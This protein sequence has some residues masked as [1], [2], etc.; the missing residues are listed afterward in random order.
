MHLNSKVKRKCKRVIAMITAVVLVCA[1]STFG[2]VAFA[3]EKD[4][5]EKTMVDSGLAAQ[6][7]GVAKVVKAT[8]DKT[9]ADKS[10][11]AMEQA[12]E[13][14]LSED[15]CDIRKMVCYVYGN[16]DYR[17]TSDGVTIDSYTG[18]EENIVIP[19]VINGYAVT[20]IGNNAFSDCNSIKRITI[21]NSVTTIGV[22][23]FAE[24]SNL[25][26]VIIPKS[27]TTIGSDAFSGCTNLVSIT[28]PD[29]VTRLYN[30]FTGCTKLENVMLP[31]TLTCMGGNFQHCTSL[32][33]ITIPNSVTKMDG[34]DFYYC[35]NLESI[36]I[37]G[38]VES[39]GNATFN[40]CSNLK[41]VTISKGVSSI[42]NCAFGGC[43]SLSS[44]TIPGSVVS[45][46]YNAFIGCVEME[47]VIILDGVKEIMEQAFCNCHKLN[48]VELP[49]SVTKLGDEVFYGCSELAY[50]KL[51]NNLTYISY[52]LFEECT[53]LSSIIIPNNITRIGHSFVNCTNLSKILIPE[54]VESI[55]S[56][57]FVGCDDLII[58]CTKDSSAHYFAEQNSI[59]YSFDDFSETSIL[60]R[61]YEK[62][63][64]EKI[65]K[66]FNILG[67]I[68]VNDAKDANFIYEEL[69]R[70]E[71]VVG[72][73]SIVKIN[74]CKIENQINN[75]YATFVLNASALKDGKTNVTG[76]IDGQSVQCE[77]DVDFFAI[78][79][80]SNSFVH[81]SEDFGINTYGIYDGKSIGKVYPTSLE[82]YS[83]LCSNL[84]WS[85]EISLLDTMNAEEWDGS[86]EG[87]S[88]SMALANM[89]KLDVSN[90]GDSS[91]DYYSKLSK[92]A[93]NLELRDLINY[94]QLMQYAN[95]LS[96]TKI[97]FN[98]F[99]TKLNNLMLGWETGTWSKTEFWKS[100]FS[101][102]KTAV[103]NKVP[104][105][106][107]FGYNEGEGHTVLA[108]GYED[109]REDGYVVIKLY[110]CNASSPASVE[111]GY[112]FATGD[113][114]YLFVSED[115]SSFALSTTAESITPY[116]KYVTEDNWTYFKYYDMDSMNKIDVGVENNV[117]KSS[118]N[119]SS[120]DIFNKKMAIFQVGVSDKLYLEN[121]DGS[122]LSFDGTEYS[123][124]MEVYDIQIV[125]GNNK[126]FKFFIP[127]DDEF[128]LKKLQDD[129]KYSIL[130]G[131]KYYTV[132]TTG[133]D[134]VSVSQ[135]DGVQI[136]GENYSFALG[137]SSES[138]GELTYVSGNCTQ[139][140]KA[141][142]LDEGIKITTKGEFFAVDI[143]KITENSVEDTSVEGTF[144]EANTNDIA[145]EIEVSH[146]TVTPAS[147][148]TS[149]PEVTVSPQTS[150]TSTTIPI[151]TKKP[152]ANPIV[153]PSTTEKATMQPTA[154]LSASE[155]PAASS[156]VVK[157]ETK[158]TVG[159]NIYTIT[160]V[161]K[162]TVSFY[163]LVKKNTKKATLPETIT[164]NGKKY[165]VT[166]I[167]EKA[168]S[169]NRTITAV[170]IGKNVTDIGAKVFYKCVKLTKMT[171]PSK[172][173][174]IGKQAFEG[175]SKLNL[176]T[177]KTT[178]LTEKNVGKAA[179]KGIAKKA[180]IKVPKSKK[181][182]YQK[183]LKKKGISSKVKVK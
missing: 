106:F 62:K 173:N 44:I 16:F 76:S 150:E 11:I 174:K 143:K 129:S 151:I 1:N 73:N 171:I 182:V 159:N 23:A 117:R 77:I 69:Q 148:Y 14:K 132:E 96:P 81:N 39:I 163:G 120:G 161:S 145:N 167:R 94:Y 54:N 107:G 28:I 140:S 158:I 103:K 20:A 109:N 125:G 53:N 137:I 29:G 131:D 135:N 112:S 91:A 68:S 3:K 162:R 179:F 149:V 146:P 100:C 15:L 90:I 31:N 26:D 102:I 75:Y 72:D 172:V 144:S 65:G 46:G 180:V 110:D 40:M 152:T 115:L 133:A 87:L 82:Y 170:T 48:S 141:S 17:I 89:G 13:N 101:D 49:D 98:K 93:N 58:Y 116:N 136:Y 95:K 139:D 121:S 10:G 119:V 122:F 70:I 85:E 108:C 22:Y 25:E 37:P 88:I 113:Y 169:G 175:C 83:K 181:K 155:K 134:S 18:N 55:D 67:S 35:T 124:D 63:L 50:V 19:D 27:V 153:T 127:T 36:T 123:G 97:Y 114:L 57:A 12:K 43:T 118:L 2:K 177:I 178:K 183:M 176:I 79:Y 138:V 8:M 51:S 126:S 99:L 154:T 104:V 45:I 30:V 128:Y 24:C 168:L 111:K 4:S 84:D 156:A 52:G 38:S 147:E 9:S 78:G 42:G 165:K 41:S 164:Y 166:A 61:L 60:L 7:A 66:D 105:L 71:W 80:D 160:N 92:P 5:A 130:V 56:D 34:S 142:F 59:P 21:P 86:C 47:N 6:T 64:S 74:S 32:K 33:K 157:K